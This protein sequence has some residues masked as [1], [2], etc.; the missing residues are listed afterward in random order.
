MKENELVTTIQFGSLA[1]QKGKGAEHEG[2]GKW[3]GG[4]KERKM[5]RV[6]PTLLHMHTTTV[7]KHK[8]FSRLCC[9]SDGINAVGWLSHYQSFPRNI[10]PPLKSPPFGQAG[11]PPGGGG[12]QSQKDGS[13]PGGG[14]APQKHTTSQL[15]LYIK[16]FAGMPPVGFLQG[17][18]FGA[19]GD[20][21]CIRLKK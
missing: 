1:A 10:P 15:R 7:I 18:E 8:H 11:S 3:G 4:D 21:G 17:A 14:G 9:A 16:F 12:G 20:V 19:V 5:G 2:Q 13:P 6:Y